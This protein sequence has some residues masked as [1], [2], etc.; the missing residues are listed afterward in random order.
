MEQFVIFFGNGAVCY[1]RFKRKGNAYSDN[2]REL[3][4]KTLLEKVHEKMEEE[5]C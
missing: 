2:S 1:Y 5:S 3:N 4:T